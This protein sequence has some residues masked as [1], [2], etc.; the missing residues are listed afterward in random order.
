SD[1]ARVSFVRAPGRFIL[2]R[3]VAE[4][5]ESPFKASARELVNACFSRPLEFHFNFAH[6]KTSEI[7]L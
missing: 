1:R 5:V 4:T 6:R 7:P 3:L 2:F